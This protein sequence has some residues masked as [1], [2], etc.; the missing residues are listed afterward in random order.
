MYTSK[1]KVEAPALITTYTVSNNRELIEALLSL[2][3]SLEEVSAALKCAR[4]TLE[5]H[6]SKYLE[7]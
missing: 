5:S 2:H 4:Q 1:D 3:N 6:G 7:F